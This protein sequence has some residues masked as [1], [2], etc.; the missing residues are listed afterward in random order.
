[1]YLSL[2]IFHWSFVICRKNPCQLPW[3]SLCVLR[4]S[5][6]RFGVQ[7][8]ACY[9]RRAAW[10]LRS[11]PRTSE[12]CGLFRCGRAALCSSVFIGGFR[13]F[14]NPGRAGFAKSFDFFSRALVEFVW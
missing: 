5:A 11:K 3:T 4:V 14:P 2:F 13:P 8:L 1:F 9:G 12:S 10:R 6:V 7:A